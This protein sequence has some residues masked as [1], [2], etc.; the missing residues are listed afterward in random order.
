LISGSALAYQALPALKQDLAIW[1]A[2][3]VH[4]TV[5]EGYLQTSIRMDP[6]LD[7][8]FA[9]GGPQRDAL[10][11]RGGVAPHKIRLAPTSADASGRFNPE[12]YADR[13]PEI[14]RRLGLR[15]GEVVL[16]YI[17]R[18]AVEKDVPLF[19]QTAGEIVRRNPQR[20]FKVFIAGDGPER[21]RVEHEIR[22]QGL[23]GVVEILGF[24]DFVP[25]VLAASRFAFLTS[26][27][28]GSSVTLLEAMAM[29]L[30]VLAPEVGNVR[31]VVQD[32]VNGFVVPSRRPED[33]ARRVGEALADPVREAE[34][35]RQA[36]RTILDR[37]DLRG[38]VQVYAEAIAQAL[39]AR[40]PPA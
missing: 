25:E 29:R 40:R 33:F 15:G 11:G 31:D 32:G 38:M 27:F 30:V 4:N 13:L 18:L 20:R 19:V 34:I 7:C 16:S 8:H 6:Y 39:A 23:P 10:I 12:A 17:G 5:P 24:C 21:A 1:T 37:F 3:I 36:R 14:R 2:D 22:A 35:G 28:E 9:V 26:R